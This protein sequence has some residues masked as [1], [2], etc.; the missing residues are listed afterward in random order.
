MHLAGGVADFSVRVSGGVVQKMI[1]TEGDV[2]PV[3]GGNRGGNGADGGL[4]C[5][6]N[7]SGIVVENAHEF[8][9]VFCLCWSELTGAKG[10]G[11]LLCLAIDWCTVGMW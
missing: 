9:T 3:A 8:L 6:V 5:I 4:H 2:V 11:I 1:D 10:L 7:G